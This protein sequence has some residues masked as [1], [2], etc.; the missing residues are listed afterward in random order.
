MPHSLPLE[1][2]AHPP[3]DQREDEPAQQHRL[4][5]PPSCCRSRSCSLISWTISGP[6]GRICP[7]LALIAPRS[8]FLFAAV[9]QWRSH[10]RQKPE[11]FEL[12]RFSSAASER[13]R[14]RAP[15]S[16]VEARHTPRALA[17]R[18]L[19]STDGGHTFTLHRL[20]QLLPRHVSSNN[21]V[22]ALCSQGG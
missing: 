2:W 8:S 10:L 14:L 4:T 9:L 22:R 19:S 3:L 17:N 1:R 7:S 12:R 20:G 13:R 5:W 6:A 18:S 11:L 21:E 16:R 15:S